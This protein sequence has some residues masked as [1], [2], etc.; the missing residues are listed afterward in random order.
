MQLLIDEDD[1]QMCLRKL[2]LI[3]TAYPL[4]SE[5]RDLEETYI[6]QYLRTYKDEHRKP[7]TKKKKTIVNGT[8]E[9]DL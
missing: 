4:L 5:G 6:E 8:V 2:N 7:A 3:D 9:E 1:E